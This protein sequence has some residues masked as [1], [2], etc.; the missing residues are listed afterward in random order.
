MNEDDFEGFEDIYMR[1]T[2][3]HGTGSGNKSKSFIWKHLRFDPWRKL[4]KCVH[5]RH[6]FRYTGGGTTYL[7]NHLLKHGV[8]SDRNQ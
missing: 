1:H 6:E 8:S 3:L 4:V 2:G 7:R 5:C